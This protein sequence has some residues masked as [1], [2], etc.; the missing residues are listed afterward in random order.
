M[1]DLAS[2]RQTLITTLF[3]GGRTEGGGSARVNEWAAMS[4][5]ALSDPRCG[6]YCRHAGITV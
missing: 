5:S 2:P 3:E 1:V 4:P 6:R